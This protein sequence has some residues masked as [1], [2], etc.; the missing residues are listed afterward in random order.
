[1][2]GGSERS[3]VVEAGR[4]EGAPLPTA[5]HHPRAEGAVAD[6]LG[7]GTAVTAVIARPS[8]TVRVVRR[9]GPDRA[10]RSRRGVWT[11]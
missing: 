9:S 1:M 5:P 11:T 7:M 6:V 2:T 8:A 3:D 4:G 10:V